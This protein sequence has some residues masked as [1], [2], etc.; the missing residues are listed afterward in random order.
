MSFDVLHS[1]VRFLGSMLP[2]LP[3]EP[4]LR[5]Y[6]AWWEAEGKRIS[7]ATDR[8]GTPWLRMFDR[9]GKRIDEILYPPEYWR[10]LKR[11]YEAGAVW[12]GFEPD[13]LVPCHLLNY[14]TCFYDPG[15][16]CPYTVSL[17]TAVPLA[18]YGSEELK[19]R[20]LAP[21]LRKDGAPGQ[22][23]TWMTEIRGGSDLG[24]AVETVARPEGGR[25]RLTGDKYFCSNV[26]AEV[27]LVAARPEGA[28]RNVHGLVPFLV[29]R[30]RE[31]GSLNYFV[32]RLKDKIGTRSV[33]TGEV[34]L[35]DS[36]AYLLGRPEQ[37]IHLLFEV[38]NISRVEN[39]FGSVAVMQRAL[40]EAH[41]FAARRIAF[42]KP[43]LDHPLM[44]KQFD[45]RL[46]ALKAAF[47][48]A[49]E[50]ATRLEE[51]RRE[52]PPYSDRFHL[53]RLVAHLAKFWTAELAVQTAKWGMEVHGGLGVLQ[54]YPAERWF[55]EAIIFAVWEG[56]AHR[57]ILDGLEAMERKG[58][59]RL[60]FERLSPFA[61][62]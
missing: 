15:L 47:A 4:V 61:V 39:S 38:F 41:A 22:G 44:R 2:A 12:R 24:A 54:E 31:D 62:S 3:L 52:F 59:H 14:V 58:A 19:A 27:A 42:G 25:W 1:P 53:F 7:D 9:F 11:G 28:P 20:F 21:M 13:S 23:A 49:W 35:R 37:G 36:E 56:A 33:P 46:A 5:E 26:G 29:P 57:Q 18:K 30:Q 50:A 16:A 51:V 55:R 17:A 10:A 6:E 45:E 60:L 34:E 40:A 8:A 32:R 48:L 43:I